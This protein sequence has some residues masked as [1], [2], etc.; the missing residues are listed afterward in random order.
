MKVSGTGDA[1]AIRP[2]RG[3]HPQAFDPARICIEHLEFD[4]RWMCDYL[5]PFGHAPSETGNQPAKRIDFLLICGGAQPHA[6][7]LFEQLDRSTRIGDEASIGAF[8]QA[9]SLGFVVFVLD[10]PDDFL[11]EV[12]DRDQTIDAAKL[13]DHHRDVR[14]RL[15]HLHEQVKDRHRRRDKEHLAQEGEQ[16]CLTPLGNRAQDILDV[17]EADHV[18]QRLAID[19]NARVTLLDHTRDDLGEGRLD[20]ERDDV[21]TWHHDISRRPVVHFQD[22]SDENALMPAQ[23]F[24]VVRARFLD[25]L[26]EGLTQAFAVAWTSDHAKKIAQPR[27]GS[28]VLWLIGT[29]GRFGIAHGSAD[30]GAV[31]DIVSR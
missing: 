12:L 31:N 14:A 1:A 10:L 22:I 6:L 19:R 20:V 23:R 29:T 8:Y 7:M 26:V 5:A 16:L 17:N 28:F 2:R 24:A 30:W 18:V 13:V 15:A 9:R 4:T 21:D 11:D 27:K 25:H 3:A